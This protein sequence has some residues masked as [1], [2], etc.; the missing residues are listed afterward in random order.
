MYPKTT[1]PLDKTGTAPKPTT[2]LKRVR[3][4]ALATTTAIALLGGLVVWHALVRSGPSPAAEDV[5]ARQERTSPR[6][7]RRGK[8]PIPRARA[9]SSSAST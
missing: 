7:A 2:I 3:P 9:A 1:S 4:S 8:C 5:Q 6:I